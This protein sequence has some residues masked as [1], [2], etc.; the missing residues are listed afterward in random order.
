MRWPAS[1]EVYRVG[2]ESDS[3]LSPGWAPALVSDRERVVLFFDSLYLAVKVGGG[4]W[5]VVSSWVG[6]EQLL[7]IKFSAWCRTHRY[8]R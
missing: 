1:L 4:G 2:S 3:S 8:A 5:T 6:C 7:C